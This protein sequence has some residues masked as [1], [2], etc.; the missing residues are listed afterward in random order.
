M[1]LVINT[2]EA[3]S[4]SD[5]AVLA[6]LTGV[7]TTKAAP[8]KAAPAPAKEEP[9]EDLLGG[10]GPTMADAVALAT[11]LVSEGQAAKVKEALAGVG[12][13]RVSE[14][15]DDTIATFVSSLSE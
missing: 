12:A 8:K 3:L 1:Y 6:Q 9:E 4:E 5:M 14:L 2:D 10:S 7:T 13:K 11:K 15:T